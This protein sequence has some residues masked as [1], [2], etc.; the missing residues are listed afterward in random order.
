[1]GKLSDENNSKVIRMR[2]YI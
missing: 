1:M 2:W